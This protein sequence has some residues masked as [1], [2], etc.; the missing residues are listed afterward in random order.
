[1][2]NLCAR[3]SRWLMLPVLIL[4]LQ[5]MGCGGV[6]VQEE[7]P[8]IAHVHIGHAQTGWKHSPGQKG[9]FEVAE[10]RGK[11]ALA[12]AKA[13][14]IS[15]NPDE[16]KKH[17]QEMVLAV[18]VESVKEV[19]G[20]E[21][22]LENGLEEA[23]NHITF[24]ADSEDASDNVKEFAKKFERDAEIVLDRSSLI[25]ALGKEILGSSSTIEMKTLAEELVKLNSDNV[26]GGDGGRELGLA[27]LR[28]SLD[29]MISR[30]NPKY[31]PVATRYL[32]GLVKLPSGKW[33][34][35]WLVGGDDEAYEGY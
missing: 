9:L 11:K 10:E 1:M 33:A 21:F 25:V 6:F 12:S 34:F 4:S 17:I 22:G 23:V 26:F 27:Q 29:G 35:S 18:S 14:Q 13:A 3:Y 5:F 24:A 30:E 7:L 8:T 32:F 28:A 20:E 31:E 16:I 19:E 15:E 2:Q